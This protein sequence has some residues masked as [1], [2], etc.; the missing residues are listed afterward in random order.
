MAN[1]I[2]ALNPY[3]WTSVVQDFLNASLVAT[4]ICNTKCEAYLTSGSRV[5]FPYMSDVRV[6]SYT[7]GTDLTVDA[8]TATQ[9]YLDVDQSKVVVFAIDPVQE[10]QSLANYGIEMARQATFQLRNNIDQAV[11]AS[12]VSAA[13]STVAGG[14]L[15]TSTLVSKMTDVY[16]TLARKNAVDG[17]LFAVV[18]PETASLLSQTFIANGFNIADNTLRNG[19]AG[20]AVGFSVY[21]S[22]NLLNT[23]VLT[24]DTQP[25]NT[26]TMTILGVTWT[27][28]TDGTAA[29]AG[30]INI[31]GD[32]ADAKLILVTALNGTTPPTAGDYVDISTANR[33]IYQNAQLTASAFST[34]AC[35]ITAYGKI[36]ATE[37]FTAATN[38]F[39]TET[40]A[41][42]FGRKGAV[43]LAIQMQPEL[44]IAQEPKQRAKNWMTSVLFG[45]KTFVRDAQRLVKM[46]RNVV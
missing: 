14:T 27:W 13:G 21:V 3:I 39:G 22:N 33:R 6:Q 25:T 31:G 1:A 40:T 8:L 36:A 19:F 42:L 16:S 41:L 30:E 12:G 35:T 10:K 44:T 38:V 46:T 18:D 2:T 11:L 7:Q 4:E 17:E 9:D 29:A 37:T 26:N 15:T 5:N 28:V 23:V 43:S 24:M 32:V 20:M 34:H 45:T